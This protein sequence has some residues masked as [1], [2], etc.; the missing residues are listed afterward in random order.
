MKK[1]K[2]ILLVCVAASI[3]SCCGGECSYDEERLPTYANKSGEMVKIVSNYGSTLEKFI[4]NGDTLHYTEGEWFVPSSNPATINCGGLVSSG[5]CDPI[6]MRLYFLDVPRKCLIFEGPIKNDGI[7]MRSWD[8]Y[9]R[10]KKID[11]WADFWAGVE[12]VYTITHQ[13]REMAKGGG[14]QSSA[15]TS[16]AGITYDSPTAGIQIR[17]GYP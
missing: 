1:L 13:H 7:D 12:Y 5:D 17:I 16:G 2:Y 11:G 8:S 14:C 15:G 6:K 9:K 4:A 10:G 3:A